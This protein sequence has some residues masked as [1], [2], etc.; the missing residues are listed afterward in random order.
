MREQGSAQGEVASAPPIGE[1]SVVA[2]PGEAAREHVQE[3][4]ADE[5]AGVEAHH[6]ELVCAGVVAPAQTHLLAVEVDEAVVG[7]GG[8][9]GVAPEV[10]HDVGGAGERRLG[11]DDPVVRLQRGLQ[12]LEGAAVV[13]AIGAGHTQ[14]A[15]AMGGGEEV[16]ILAAKDL[17]H[18]GGG[19]EETAAHGGQPALSVRTQGA[20]GDDAVD[21]DVLPQILP[22]GVEHD[23]DAELA[24]L[25]GTLC[26]ATGSVY[27]R[28]NFTFVIGV[29]PYHRLAQ[30]ARDRHN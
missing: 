5:L 19:E 7:D 30:A 28:K 25:G 2:Q 8:L 14:F 13:E 4:S 10:G 18:G 29:Q 26:Y 16:E 12:A 1:Q 11:V 23:G 6:L 22:P 3:E 20:V 15:V 27:R 17:R 21:M 9:V 24:A